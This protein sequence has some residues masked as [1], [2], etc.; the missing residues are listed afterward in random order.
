MRLRSTGL[1][2]TELEAEV[3]SA[4][5][6]DD[7]VIFFAKVTKPVKWKL[8]MGFQEKDLRA[9][10]WAILKPRNLWFIIKSMTFKH[11]AISTT[12][13]FQKGENEI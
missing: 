11:K 2:R 3:I 10:F 4:K 6:V 8:R 13:D 12:K 7:M 9:L 1:G 5:K